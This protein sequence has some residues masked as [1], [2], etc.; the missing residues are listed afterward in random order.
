MKRGTDVSIT[1]GKAPLVLVTD[2]GRGSAIAIIRS[3]GRK[4]YRVIA[5]DSNPQSLGFY[6]RYASERLVYPAPETNPLEF[7]DCLLSHAKT[8]GID[9]IIPATDLAIQPLA[10]ARV[11]FDGVTRLALP[12]NS[13][14]EVVTD[15][16]KTVDLAKR[17]GVP[18]PATFLVHT[19]EE[20]LAK[21]DELGWPIVLKPQSSKQMREDKGIDSFKVTYAND[22]SEL[23]TTMKAFEGRCAVLLQSY[24]NGIGLGVELLMHDGE[25]LAAFQH[26]RRREIPLT[27][28]ASAYRESVPLDPTL[29]DYSVRLL[30]EHRWTGLAMVEFKANGLG[31]KL[32]EINGRVWG[33]LPLAVASGVDFPGMLADM[34]MRG[35]GSIMPQL[36]THYKLGVRCRDVQRDLMWIVSVFMQRRRYP[37]LKMPGRLAALR[38]LLG[39]FNPMRKFDLLT[40]DDP[41]P[42][43]MEFPRVVK[44]F[45]SKMRESEE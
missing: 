22:R 20:A 42:G 31:A 3:L 34:Y 18:V 28:G 6:S 26:K 30:R 35:A 24:C 23:H 15:K 14:L 13:L 9:L 44:K 5:A 39:F 27:G 37:F 45:R 36:D 43:I 4:G 7:C 11:S 21:V 38:A 2:A 41:L 17:L 19:A 25:P 33:S 32:M 12:E 16:A 40:L 8:M 1:N 29:Y 10:R